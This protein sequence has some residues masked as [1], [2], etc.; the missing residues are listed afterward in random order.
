MTPRKVLYIVPTVGI[1]GVETFIKNVS[2]YHSEAFQPS[3]LLFQNGPLGH[4]LEDKEATVYYCPHK[5]R[6]SRPWT[7]W[8]YKKD[9]L[10]LI[11]NNNIEIV[12]SSMAY[13][14]LF[15]WPA[16]SICPHVWFQHGPVSGWMDKLAY[17]L[18]SRAV[19]YNSK[20]T[21]QEQIQWNP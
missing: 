19:L 13:A 20:H 5:P 17:K 11:K 6:L 16:D 7:W 21:Y 12:H 10:T 15:S 1:G 18:P 4:W 14:A 2:Q 3:F 8:L 9:L